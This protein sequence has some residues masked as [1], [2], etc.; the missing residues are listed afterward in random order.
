MRRKDWMLGFLG[1]LGFNGFPGIAGFAKGDWIQ[2][3]DIFWFS[4]LRLVREFP[5]REG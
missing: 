2:A 1:F 3:I 4:I 5:S